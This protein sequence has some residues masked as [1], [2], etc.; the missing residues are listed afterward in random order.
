MRESAHLLHCFNP[1]ISSSPKFCFSVKTTHP[2]Q[3]FLQIR[4]G[5]I[6]STSFSHTRTPNLQSALLCQCS[7]LP[8]I[9]SLYCCFILIICF[10][11]RFSKFLTAATVATAQTG[12]LLFLRNNLSPHKTRPKYGRFVLVRRNSIVLLPSRIACRYG[13]FRITRW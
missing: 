4:T 9:Q 2:R 3:S 12:P 7:S 1:P 6:G 5:L 11:V 13:F 8:P 10:G